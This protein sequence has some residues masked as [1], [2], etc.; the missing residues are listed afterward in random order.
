MDQSLQGKVEL[1]KINSTGNNKKCQEMRDSR[2]ICSKLFNLI[3]QKTDEIDPANSR[4][5]CM[6]DIALAEDIVQADVFFYNI[7]IVDGSVIGELVRS[8]AWKN[9]ITVQLLR[10]NSHI[11]CLCY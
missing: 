2:K 4:R 8:S 3:L 9:S 7:Y 1:V 5:V 11:C 10:S 6:E